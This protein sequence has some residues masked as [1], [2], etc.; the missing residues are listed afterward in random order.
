MDV[1][2][3]II[4]NISLLLKKSGGTI[5]NIETVEKDKNEI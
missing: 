2:E 1:G 4:C 3:K 5:E